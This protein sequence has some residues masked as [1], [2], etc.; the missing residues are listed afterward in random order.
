MGTP[1]GV[2]ID[3]DGKV[4][5]QLAVGVPEVLALLSTD[6]DATRSGIIKASQNEGAVA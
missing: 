4:A 5:S 1:S 3:K 6:L 2:L